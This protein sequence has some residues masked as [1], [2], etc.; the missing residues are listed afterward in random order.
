MDNIMEQWKPINGFS[1]YEISNCGR[2]KHVNA[3]KIL[4]GTTDHFGYLRYM[5]M[6]DEGKAVGKFAHV[7]VAMAFI[8]N[9]NPKVKTIVNHKDEDKSNPVAWN[10]EWVT[11]KEN[12]NYGTVKGRVGLANRKPVNEYD[13][14]GK[15]IRT[16]KSA[17][18][19]S[20]IYPVCSRN[21]QSAA[22]GRVVLAYGR[23]WRYLHGDDKSDIDPVTNKYPLKYLPDDDYN[24]DIPSEFL[25]T[26]RKLT[27]AELYADKLDKM[28]NS[29]EIP[30]YF[31]ME[32]K[33]IQKYI[34]E[35]CK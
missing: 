3:R 28:I 7:L 9:D 5:L 6:S 18:F 35:I 29:P 11:P 34:L 16:W 14:N 19:A 4:K 31:I 26:V 15:Y 13:I 2:V 33:N 17:Q 10:L 1:R 25:Y 30:T 32:L 23:Q 24:Y 12:S 21:I 20:K 8:P 22:S 27:G